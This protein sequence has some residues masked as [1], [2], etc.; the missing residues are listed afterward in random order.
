MAF[1]I[2][3]KENINNI[4]TDVYYL[5]DDEYNVVEDIKGNFS[6][7]NLIY[8]ANEKGYKLNKRL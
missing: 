7:I 5:V 1:I 3:K 4:K 8:E 2:K 6:K